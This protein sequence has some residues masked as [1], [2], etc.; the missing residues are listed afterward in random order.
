MAASQQY[1]R[2]PTEPKAARAAA[3]L[4]SLLLC[5]L[6]R[7]L[8]CR[9]PSCPLPAC[10]HSG[11]GRAVPSCGSLRST[12]CRRIRWRYVVLDEAHRVKNDKST[13]HERLLQAPPT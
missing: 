12:L 2:K 5:L 10:N 6:R 8:P 7:S 9:A 3:L 4:N 1:D 13:L 11:L